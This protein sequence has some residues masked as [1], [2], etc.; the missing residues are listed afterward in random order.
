MM[1]SVKHSPGTTDA[2]LRRYVLD[3]YCR[4]FAQKGWVYPDGAWK[5][6]AVVSLTSGSRHAEH[7][8]VASPGKPPR[9]VPCAKVETA[10]PDT[11][12]CAAYRFARRSEVRL[13]LAKLRKTHPSVSC[14]DGTP[15]AQL[16][17]P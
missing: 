10:P 9:T 16:G 17:V 6:D 5:I 3:A 4:R 11:L 8:A 1:R 7:C 14:D 13:Y 2:Q 15:L 12:D